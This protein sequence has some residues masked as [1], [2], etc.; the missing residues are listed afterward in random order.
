LDPRYRQSLQSVVIRQEKVDAGLVGRSPWTARDAPVPLPDVED[1]PSPRV[2]APALHYL[3][4]DMWL[5]HGDTLFRSY[6]CALRSFCWGGILRKV[7]RSV[8]VGITR[9][10][11]VLGS[12]AVRQLP[13]R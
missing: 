5:S 7:L 6:Q 10:R 9:A 3:A 2:S 12:G 11:I 1:G 13:E 8:R 4:G